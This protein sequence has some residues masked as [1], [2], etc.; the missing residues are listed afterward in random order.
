MHRE[1]TYK[2]PAN[3]RHITGIFLPGRME[4]S[5]MSLEEYDP[6]RIILTTAG[7]DKGHEIARYL[8][9][10]KLAACVNISDV[11]SYYR[12]K[13]E[14]CCDQEVILVIK[15][16]LSRVNDAV[17]ELKAIH[18]YELPEIIVL[19]VKGGYQPYLAWVREE[20]MS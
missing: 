4:V 10:K 7:K 20:T 1:R 12:W 11:T 5:F 13:G 18:P 3:P 2:R 15:T 14:F 8:V 19:P 9:E 6:V 16:T 17:K